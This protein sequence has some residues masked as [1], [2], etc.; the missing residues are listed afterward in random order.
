[1]IESEHDPL[2]GK[3]HTDFN[4]RLREKLAR[5]SNYNRIA[6]TAEPPARI[7]ALDLIAD[8]IGRHQCDHQCDHSRY[9]GIRQIIVIVH[10]GITD[11]LGLNRHRLDH[12]RHHSLRHSGR[13]KRCLHDSPGRRNG[14][15]L[16]ALEH[17]RTR[18]EVGQVAVVADCRRAA[19]DS[20]LL[21]VFRNPEK[22]IDLS[23]S[24]L[25]HCRMIGFRL[26]IYVRQLRGLQRPRHLSRQRRLVQIDDRR[27]NPQRQSLIHHVNEKESCQNRDDNQAYQI[28]TP[29]NQSSDAIRK[30]LF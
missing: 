26:L 7:A 14:N 29:G 28:D 25:L 24:N 10:P 6:R 23:R 9:K 11:R 13:D 2:T 22:A 19:A 27:R 16:E 20:V 3:T 18:N 1:M 21:E 30:R 12:R 8:R 15:R 17:E 4:D 5:K